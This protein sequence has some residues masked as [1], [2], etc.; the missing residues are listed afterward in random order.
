MTRKLGGITRMRHL[1]ISPELF[2]ALS[3]RAKQ[4]HW[5]STS[6]YVEFEL[7][8]TLG[9]P[10]EGHERTA[11]SSVFCVEEWEGKHCIFVRHAGRRYVFRYAQKSA[12]MAL[13]TMT[14]LEKNFG[15]P[16][17]IATDLAFN[18]WHCGYKPS[19]KFM[20]RTTQKDTW[21]IQEPDEV[22]A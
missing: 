19:F 2:A 14:R 1:H 22:A 20:Q 12:Q 3:M 18:Y 6:K 11:E 9:M 17:D 13:E 10:T 4:W 7:R 21:Y 15:K 8:R 16:K 5:P